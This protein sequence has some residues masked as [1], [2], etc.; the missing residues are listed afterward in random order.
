MNSNLKAHNAANRNKTVVIG[1]FGKRTVDMGLRT[2]LQNDGNGAG[3]R[4]Q[5]IRTAL[6]ATSS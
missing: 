1:G 4:P 6:G 5:D 2:Q 3:H